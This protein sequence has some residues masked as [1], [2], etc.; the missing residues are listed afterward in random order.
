[1]SLTREY[2][3]SLDIEEEK[4]NSI[5]S[6]YSESQAE[7]TAELRQKLESKETEIEEIKQSFAKK[8]ADAHRRVV[9][10]ENLKKS[11][12][13]ESSAKLIV[14]RSDFAERLEI[15]ENGEP[16]NIDDVISEIQ[17]DAD[18][19]GFTPKIEDFVHKPSAPPSNSNAGWTKEKIM[20]VKNTAERQG[21]IAKNPRIFG[22]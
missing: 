17:A 21:L 4:I 10:L 3:E 6:A 1:M 13:S 18:F 16:A 11:G 7:K 5:I 12:Y 22:I 14:N 15:A 20:A 2:L 19:S 9:L 8:E